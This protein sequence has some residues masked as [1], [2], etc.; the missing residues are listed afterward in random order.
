MQ[1]ADPLRQTLDS[2]RA[3]LTSKSPVNLGKDVK[4]AL[5]GYSGGA[6]ANEWATELQVQYA[7]EL[8]YAGAALGGL[9]PNVSSVLFTINGTI[10]A[11]LAP[12]GIL[13]LSSQYPDAEAYLQ[14]HLR[15]DGDPIYNKAN[16]NKARNY[17]LAEAIGAYAFQDLGKYFDNGIKAIEA[18]VSQ[19]V[20]NR[21]GVMGYHG[22]P[23]PPL[24][25]YKAIGD[26]ISVIADT[27]KL[28]DRYC[29]VG[30]TIQ[31]ERNTKGNHASETYNGAG[32]ATDFLVKI[33]SG[34]YTNT[35][36]SVKNVTVGV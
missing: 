23:Q 28:V 22:V 18:P 15:N 1:N 11:G 2:T 13:G 26:D 8:N 9:T 24:F 5:W 7:S 16:F 4:Y 3:L 21:D 32:R 19:K 20:I 14:S 33:F 10:Y 12:S 34:T 25:V 31:Y 29:G 27:D 6:L 17:T 36:C 30:A 35:G